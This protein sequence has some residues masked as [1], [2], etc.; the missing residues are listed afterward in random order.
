LLLSETSKAFTSYLF[1]R[2]ELQSQALQALQL[3]NKTLTQANNSLIDENN[4][5]HMTWANLVKIC[6][7]VKKSKEVH[8]R[9]VADLKL[10]LTTKVADFMAEFAAVKAKLNADTEHDVNFWLAE[11]QAKKTIVAKLKAELEAVRQ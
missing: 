2:I 8:V 9:Q 10:L 5:L 4:W 3:K 11:V 7:E 1:D 6:L